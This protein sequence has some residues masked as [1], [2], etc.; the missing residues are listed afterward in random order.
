LYFGTNFEFWILIFHDGGS[1]MYE[2]LKLCLF[3][4]LRYLHRTLGL[5]GRAPFPAFSSALCGILPNG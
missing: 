4:Y 5:F 2:A 1:I 3:A